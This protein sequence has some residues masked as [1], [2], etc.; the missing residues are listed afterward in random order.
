[1]NVDVTHLS[2][3]EGQSGG[4]GEEKGEEGAGTQ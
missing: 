1:M 4:G 2:Q 3:T